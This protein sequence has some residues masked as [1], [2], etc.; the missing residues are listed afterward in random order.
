M[1]ILKETNFDVNI[2]G[3]ELPPQLGSKYDGNNTNL[4]NS[5]DDKK[6]TTNIIKIINKLRSCEPYKNY[7]NI[8]EPNKQPKNSGVFIIKLKDKTDKTSDTKVKE[9]NS[10][11]ATIIQINDIIKVI[12]YFD[13]YYD[14]AT[15]KY[16]KSETKSFE[17]NTDNELEF[18]LKEINN[19]LKK[20][21]KSKSS[22]HE[23]RVVYKC[24]NKWEIL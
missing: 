20:F 23:H 17:I 2:K 6:T 7:Y 16:Q 4:F 14:L 1:I 24:N 22:K 3:V 5:F 12:V 9:I 10:P 21:L 11:Y 15:N 18:V 13:G 19:F 8:Y